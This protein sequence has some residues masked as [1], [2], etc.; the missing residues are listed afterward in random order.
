MP[1]WVEPQ[2]LPDD[3]LQARL[4]D[5]SGWHVHAECPKCRA[6]VVYPL[7]LAAAK[8]GWE[9]TLGNFISKLKC[10]DDGTKPKTVRLMSDQIGD[11]CVGR[12]TDPN[13]VI[14]VLEV[15]EKDKS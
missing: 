14:V 6:G 2:P 5:V 15:P 12:P 9:T 11:E 8:A 10:K 1:E 3:P 7:R 13:V 4:I